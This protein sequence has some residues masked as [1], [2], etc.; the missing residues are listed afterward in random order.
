MINL[1]PVKLH[2]Y[3]SLSMAAHIQKEFSSSFCLETE[4][5]QELARKI[6]HYN[7]IASVMKAIIDNVDTDRVL[8]VWHRRAV[9]LGYQ[10]N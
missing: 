1:L 4:S 5:G 3:Q 2:Y 10:L 7:M 6:E 9:T 8:E